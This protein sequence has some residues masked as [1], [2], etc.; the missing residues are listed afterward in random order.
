MVLIAFKNPKKYRSQHISM[1][2]ISRQNSKLQVPVQ[3]K[4]M[5]IS[6][7]IE[8][9]ISNMLAMVGRDVCWGGNWKQE[10][11]INTSTFLCWFRYSSGYA[12]R[13]RTSQSLS[14]GGP[15]ASDVAVFKLLPSRCMQEES[16]AHEPLTCSVPVN[17]TQSIMAFRVTKICLIFAFLVPSVGKQ[18]LALLHFNKLLAIKH[19][20]FHQLDWFTLPSSFN[21]R[22]D[23]LNHGKS[24]QT[25]HQV[26][27]NC[28]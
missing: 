24:R 22:I 19:C 23:N 8:S 21:C 27:Q 26:Y 28:V 9:F 1:V 7:I 25:L 15:S 4:F 17:R 5:Q 10:T 12:L 16:P 13:M 20:L 3:Q 2:N 18:K 14:L 11:E 6:T